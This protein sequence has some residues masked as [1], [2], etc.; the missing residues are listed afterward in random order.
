MNHISI[1]TPIMNQPIMNQASDE[2]QL[3]IN[4]ILAGDNATV[5]ACAGSGKSTTLAAMVNHKNENAFYK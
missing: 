2:Q 3:I 1:N 5:D 4:H